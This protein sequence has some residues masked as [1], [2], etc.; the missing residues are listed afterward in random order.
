[1]SYLKFNILSIL[2]VTLLTAACAELSPQVLE[3]SSP[4]EPEPSSPQEPE[5]SSLTASEIFATVSPAIAS[6]GPDG[7]LHGSGFLIEGG[8]LIT[9]A[10]VAYPYMNLTVSFP[11]GTKLDSVPVIGQD[12]LADIAVLGPIDV[13]I[14]PVVLSSAAAPAIGSNIYTIGYPPPSADPPQPAFT[15]GM[16]ARYREWPETDLVYIKTSA[17]VEGGNSGGAMV[18]DTGEIV[19]LVT[20]GSS[21]YSLALA[22]TNVLPRIERIISGD[23][24]SGTASWLSHTDG[25]MRHDGTLA[26]SWDTKVYMLQEPIGTE[27]D[28]TVE[29]E[30]VPSFIISNSLNELEFSDPVESS[31]GE[32]NTA[33]ATFD[34]LLTGP[35][36]VIV[37]NA[38]EEPGSNDFTITASHALIP[39]PDS[40]DGTELRVGQTVEGT[41]DYI[42]D[43]DTYSIYLRA[44]QTVQI[45]TTSLVL[46]T[47]LDITPPAPHESETF[48]ENGGGSGLYENEDLAIYRAP[49]SGTYLVSIGDNLYNTGGYTLEVSK[50]DE[51]DSELEDEFEA[52]SE[53]DEFIWGLEPDVVRAA[54]NLQ[55]PFDEVDLASEAIS[56]YGLELRT[57]LNNA[58]N[59][60]TVNPFQFLTVGVIESGE[61]F[62]TT[63]DS[64]PSLPFS[65]T[66]SIPEFSEEIETGTFDVQ[67]IGQKALGYQYDL[68]LPDGY[69]RVH[70]ILFQREDLE[71]FVLSIS[72]PDEAAPSP[73]EEIARILDDFIID[74]QRDRN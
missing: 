1:M 12:L 57:V 9:N 67:S 43:I 15:S 33:I 45:A 61:D 37:S 18:S 46:D 72:L 34:I 65:A 13:S 48:Y 73:P 68:E 54:L 58:L 71:G 16:V 41:S 26:G 11:N 2:L 51:A 38:H 47:Y 23:D 62:P 64:P 53:L 14:E 52:G 35:H 42:E 4:Q 31:I 21:T 50:A 25:G 40:E 8:Y 66:F 5:P 60:L 7:H 32:S 59:F 24:P 27:I 44:D 19:G 17:D 28:I 55:E 36:F 56:L 20:F 10:H 74:Y 22:S 49:Y 70:L 39:I 3:P 69:V 30:G 29:S 63:E 6:I